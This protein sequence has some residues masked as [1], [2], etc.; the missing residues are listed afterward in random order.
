MEII[1]ITIRYLLLAY[2]FAKIHM[3]PIPKHAISWANIDLERWKQVMENCQKLAS[4]INI[5]D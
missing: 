1:S 2:F 3:V 4:F 5:V